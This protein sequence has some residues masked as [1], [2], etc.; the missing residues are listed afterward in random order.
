MPEPSCTDREKA[1]LGNNIKIDLSMYLVKQLFFDDNIVL[2]VRLE[3]EGAQEGATDQIASLMVLS[4]PE[5]RSPVR[6]YDSIPVYGSTKAVDFGVEPI[7]L[8][9]NSRDTNAGESLVT[10]IFDEMAEGTT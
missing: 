9:K 5:T 1:I 7:N 10:I 8:C 3:I 2:R 4:T 6:I